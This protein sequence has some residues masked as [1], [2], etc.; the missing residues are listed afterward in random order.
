MST[1]QVRTCLTDLLGA[2]NDTNIDWQDQR[3][4]KLASTTATLYNVSVSKV[5]LKNSEELA[6]CH[7]CALIACQKLVEKYEDGLQFTE[8]KIPLPPDQI[9]KLVSIFKRNIWPNSPQKD[10][11]GQPLRF[12]NVG[13]S[14]VRKS[15][16]KNARFTGIDPKTLQEQL[17]ETPSKS[18]RKR[19]IEQLKNVDLSPSKDTSLRAR[20]KLV[21][22]ADTESNLPLPVLQ[23]PKNKSG[24]V[25]IPQVFGSI[26]DDPESPLKQSPFKESPYKYT[27][28]PRKKRGK[29]NEW[30]M[31]YKKYYKPSGAELVALCNDFEL[32]EEVT[33]TIISEFKNNATYLAYPTQLVCGLVLLCT[34]IVFNQQRTEDSTIDNKLMKK[35]AAHMRTTKDEDIMEAIKITKELIDGQKWYRD[36]RIQ[37]DY[38]DGSDYRNAIAV[39]IGSMLQD[40]YEVV[41]EEQYSIWK[42][43]IIVDISLRDG[44]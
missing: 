29:Y 30:N 32:P 15:A 4:K 22:E 26:E 11:N 33:H 2:K 20:R 34:F 7:I 14:S 10:P 39:R 37:F 35:M 8:E 25:N 3:L 36:L 16:V 44:V 28:S 17:F 21:F 23:T 9:T 5:M 6:R 41:S 27:P 24:I 42:R 13:L 43:K 19:G 18:A 40:E 31:L 1:Q 38:Y 12:D